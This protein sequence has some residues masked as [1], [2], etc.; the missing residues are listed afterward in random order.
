MAL[1]AYLLSYWKYLDVT[2]RAQSTEAP[3]ERLVLLWP[4]SDGTW[5]WVLEGPEL[6]ANWRPEWTSI[7][8]DALAISPEA[9]PWLVRCTSMWRH[10]A[11]AA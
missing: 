7:A 1:T 4:V 5:L 8:N 9:R 3:L 6:V 2:G 11:A 10:V